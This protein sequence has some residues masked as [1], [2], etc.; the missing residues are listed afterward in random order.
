M[1]LLVFN[2]T[3]APVVLAAGNP[4]RTIPLSASPP[5]RGP[6]VDV[7]SELR[8]SAAVDP[9]K[10]VAGGLSAANYIALQ[11]QVG[12]GSLAY[13]WTSDP[14]YLTATLETS[15]PSPGLHAATH[16]TAGGTDVLA[17]ANATPA[18]GAVTLA[19]AIYVEAPDAA[20][21]TGVVATVDCANGAQIIAA[22]PD[23]ARHLQLRMVEGGAAITAGTCD[24][25]GRGMDGAALAE[26]LD[27]TGGTKT[28]ITAN[29]YARLTSATVVGQVG[30]GAGTTIG[31]GLGAAL[32]LPIPA[33]AASV[34]VLKTVVDTV[35]EAVAGV[36]TTARSVAPTTPANAVHDY[37]FCYSY[38][39]T[40]A[41]VAHTHNVV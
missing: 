39:V 28:V 32:G 41:Q 25:V 33:G 26:S 1:P 9:A 21:L 31:I 20:S 12:A 2:L 40:P 38:T 36:D 23:Y 14:E 30:G 18:I 13:E 37:L 29:V 10:G 24:L 3:A 27:I 15:G 8:P 4:V 5:N 17:I 35:D 7:T 16:K 6:A 34:A 19:G 11:A 22:Q